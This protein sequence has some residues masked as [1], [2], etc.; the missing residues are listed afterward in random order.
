MPHTSFQHMARHSRPVL[1]GCECG[2]RTSRQASRHCSRRRREP[3]SYRNRFLVGWV[4]MTFQRS[5]SGSVLIVLYILFVC[6]VKDHLCGLVV[7]FPC[8]RPRG[9]G[10]DSRR[11]HIFSVAEGLERGPLNLVRI[12]EMGE[13]FVTPLREPEI[14]YH[15]CVRL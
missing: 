14:L 5:S 12:R 15:N 2:N 9:P 11:C 8:C 1:T 13:I 7:T 10:L 3:H 6:E 4:R